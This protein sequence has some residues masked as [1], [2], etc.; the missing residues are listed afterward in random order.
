MSKCLIVLDHSFRLNSLIMKFAF[1]N[2][3]YISIVYVSSWYY[4]EKAKSFYKNNNNRLFEESLNYL[5]FKLLQKYNANFSILK[6]KTPIDDITKFAKKYYKGNCC[7]RYFYI[8]T[9]NK[10][11]TIFHFR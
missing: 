11:R 8:P 5:S 7:S 1:S 6:S 3:K 9:A 10:I 2:Y 4:N